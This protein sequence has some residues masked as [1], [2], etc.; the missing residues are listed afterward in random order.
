[1][2]SKVRIAFVGVFL[3]LVWFRFSEGGQPA[4]KG[5]DADKMSKPMPSFGFSSNSRAPIDVTSDSVEANQ[6]QNTV[7]FIGTSW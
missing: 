4:K 6:K 5:A 3:L 7:T 2:K 1:M